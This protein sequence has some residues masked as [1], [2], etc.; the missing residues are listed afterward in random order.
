VRFKVK[1]SRQ[2]DQRDTKLG[3]FL[4]PE[5]NGRLDDGHLHRRPDCRLKQ[6]ASFGRSLAQAKHDVQMQTR[7]AIVAFRDIANRAEQLGRA[8]KC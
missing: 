8:S 1:R 6:M 4:A 7:F 3:T 2:R 5:M